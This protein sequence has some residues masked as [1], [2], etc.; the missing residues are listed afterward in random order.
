MPSA[1][2]PLPVSAS[3]DRR[4]SRNTCSL[5][6]D[7]RA[8]VLAAL[9]AA[10]TLRDWLAATDAELLQGVADMLTAALASPQVSEVNA[11]ANRRSASARMAFDGVAR[12]TGRPVLAAILDAIGVVDAMWSLAAA[13]AERG[14][15][16]S[17]AIDTPRRRG[18]V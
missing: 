16:G 11:L 17:A 18:P 4:G 15:H 3:G 5:I 9:A 8:R 13:T 6:D 1:Q 14:W 2:R 12:D 10:A 7:G